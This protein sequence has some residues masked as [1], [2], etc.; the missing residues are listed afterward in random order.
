MGLAVRRAYL[1]AA[2][3]IGFAIAALS[4]LILKFQTKPAISTLT[5]EV[6][7][8]WADM[9][10]PEHE[11]LYYR[12][13]VVAAIL[14]YLVLAC[15][16]VRGQK[17]G[18][19]TEEGQTKKFKLWEICI[20]V[21]IIFIIFIPDAN[22]V[23]ARIT[24]FVYH[25]DS[26]FTAPGWAIKSGLKLNIDVTSEYSVTVPA[27]FTGVLNNFGHFDY[28]G[29]ITLLMILGCVYFCAFYIFIR[30]WTGQVSAAISGVII[31]ISVQ[32]FHPGVFPIVWQFP[33]ATVLRFFWD[34]PVLI[35]LAA[36]ARRGQMSYLWGASILTGVSLAWMVDTGMYLFLGLAVYAVMLFIRRKEYAEGKLSTLLPLLIAPWITAFIILAL[37]GGA[38]VQSSYWH[39]AF[40]FAGLFLQGWGALPMT[41]SL[42]DHRYIAFSFGLLIPIIYVWTLLVVATSYFL[43]QTGRLHAIACVLCIYGLGLYHY[44]VVRS[45]PTSYAV[46]CL[47]LIVLVVWGF[48]QMRR[49][50][51]AF[52]FGIRAVAGSLLLYYLMSSPLVRDY[53]ALWNPKARIATVKNWEYD[54]TFSKDAALISRLTAPKDKVPF[55]GSFETKILMEAKRK[56]FFYYFPIF[57]SDAMHML[58]FR[59]TYLHTVGRMK[60]TL[61]QFETSK[62]AYV[63]VEK[64]LFAGQIPA[65]YY[66]HFQTLTIL[67]A[68]LHEHYDPLEQGEYIVA[69]KRKGN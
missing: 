35:L 46:V 67:M 50:S 59:G 22:K 28:V 48:S 7:P 6:F 23:L 33:S 63:F 1:L 5:N 4:L 68:Y 26:A 51:S 8:E 10:K 60:K 9:L 29:I 62:P 2:T 44:Y 39:N 17:L 40:E 49:V 54:Q 37:L 12:F 19:V 69:L 47:P 30:Q 45:G 43:K 16:F 52:R 42:K 25:L 38:V 27:V 64:K 31:G 36:H 32:M 56:P 18:T 11:T 13:F 20:F 58:Q 24:D 14:A 34:M 41:N 21:G 66:Q 15:F 55:L 57:Q 53:P 61:E 65:P 3:S